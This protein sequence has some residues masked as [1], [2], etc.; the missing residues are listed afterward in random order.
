METQRPLRE[1]AKRVGVTAAVVIALVGFALVATGDGARAL[2]VLGLRPLDEVRPLPGSENV[3]REFA[4]WNGEPQET[5]SADT[6]L[7]ASMV[8]RRYEDLFSEEAFGEASAPVR[9]GPAGMPA[10]HSSSMSHETLGFVDRAGRR[11][12]VIAYRHPD[13]GSRY[14]VF[15]TAAGSPGPATPDA[16]APLPGG[17]GVPAGAKVLFRLDRGEGS[18]LAMLEAPLSGPGSFVGSFAARLRAEGYEVRGGAGG[19]EFEGS[20]LAGVV[21]VEDDLEANRTILTVLARPR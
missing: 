19:L 11:V 21:T 20:A 2:H 17:I 10:L 4:T 1:R 9:M 8:I 13:G 6:D 5:L 3:R 16:S 18:G 12:G 14:H 15:R 7:D